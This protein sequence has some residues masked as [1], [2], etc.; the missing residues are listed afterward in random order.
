MKIENFAQAGTV[1][2]SDALVT[3]SPSDK[4]EIEITS[5]VMAQFGASIEESARQVLEDLQIESGKLKIDDH[6]A[7]DCTLRSRIQTAIFRSLGIKDNL[8][9]RDKI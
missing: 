9:W 2:S 4:L 8:P 7:L 3:V 5:P 6:G 1:E